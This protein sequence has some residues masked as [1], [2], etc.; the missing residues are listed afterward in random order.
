MRASSDKIGWVCY[1]LKKSGNTGSFSIS[2]VHSLKIE[3]LLG[4]FATGNPEP[5]CT[6]PHRKSDRDYLC[7]IF[8]SMAV[9][10]FRDITMIDGKWMF[11]DP[12]REERTF[13]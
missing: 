12:P 13:C 6:L 1:W 11:I 9:S 8:T 10:P 2:D 4:S 3:V 7:Q 5:D